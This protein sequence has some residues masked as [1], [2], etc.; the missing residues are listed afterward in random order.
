MVWS[1][2]S[3]SHLRLQTGKE[4]LRGQGISHIILDTAQTQGQGKN[5]IETQQ[6]SAEILWFEKSRGQPI[7]FT[8]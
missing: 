3:C 6:M 5:M 4:D 8:D 7:E 2:V 1:V